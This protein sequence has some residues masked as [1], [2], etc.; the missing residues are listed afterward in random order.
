MS[1]PTTDAVPSN[2]RDP[3]P[4]LF[5]A[6]DMGGG[7]AERA[8]AIHLREISRSAIRPELALCRAEGPHLGTVP[9][10]VPI[11]DLG[12]R[13][14]WSFPGLVRRFRRLADSR[15]PA[16]VLSTLWSA[17]AIQLL[18]RRGADHRWRALTLLQGDLLPERRERLRRTKTLIMRRL[19]P[20]LD[21]ALAVSEAL[22][23]RFRGTFL[24][25]PSPP[26]RLLPNPVSLADL[27][28]GA[29]SLSEGPSGPEL[30][31]AATGRLVPDKGFDLLLRAL[32]LL[33]GDV[34]PWR[35]AILGEGPEREA[36]E[37]LSRALDLDH[38]VTFLGYREN[39]FPILDRCD[40][41][42]LPSRIEAQPLALLEAMALGRPVVATDCPLGLSE[43]VEDGRSGLLVPPEDPPALAGAVR[44]LLLSPEL[45]EDLGRGALAVRDRH[46]SRKV[47]RVLE[48]RILEMPGV[49]P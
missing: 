29:R 40:L 38:R 10:D 23:A 30:S 44:R 16:V 42:V 34:P 47:A 31:I 19:Y 36:L 2:A 21:G 35:L 39:P 14:R 15:R 45:R 7:G 32:A 41:F 17:D 5:L 8:L 28:R 18:A 6:P 48:R 4:V 49:G 13:S 1:W 20:R 43:V 33:G 27:D 46:D 11:H 3:V 12:K 37:A 25:G 24:R 26:T 9:G 22:A